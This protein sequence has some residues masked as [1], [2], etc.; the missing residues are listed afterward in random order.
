M[1]LLMINNLYRINNILI[2]LNSVYRPSNV[3]P[4]LDQVLFKL[5]LSLT[6]LNSGDLAG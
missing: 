3:E 5:L 2:K 6:Q 4:N 1:L